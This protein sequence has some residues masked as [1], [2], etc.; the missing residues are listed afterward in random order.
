[1]E[2]EG[3]LNERA[4][5]LAKEDA[6]AA[7]APRGLILGSGFLAGFLITWLPLLI[8]LVL[9]VWQ[10]L[11]G[12]TTPG[13]DESKFQM[14]LGNLLQGWGDYASVA[15]LYSIAVGGLGVLFAYLRALSCRADWYLT[16]ETRHRAVRL[17]I[18]QVI[19]L[20]GIPILVGVIVNHLVGDPMAFYILLI[21][22][23]ISGLLFNIVFR[24]LQNGF[25]RRFYRVDPVD[26]TIQGLQVYVPRQLGSNH[27]VITRIDVDRET[28]IVEVYG[29]FDADETRREVRQVV[30][31]FL[32]GY[33]PVHIRDA[34]PDA[35]S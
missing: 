23:A 17:G 27:A 18:H 2:H 6:M 7:H 29:K 20:I 24:W 22:I 4:F 26:L 32:R 35:A 15:W 33:S 5:E 8:Y 11:F 1:M 9:F 14:A 19:G 30:E 34:E 16:F 28:K 3:I 31:H 13:T 12:T 21:P 10:A 25:L